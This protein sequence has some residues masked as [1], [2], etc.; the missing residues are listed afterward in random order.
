MQAHTR[1]R[2]PETERVVLDAISIEE[3]WA[4]L[5][6]FNTL[7]RLSGSQD[8]AEAVA[9]LTG[10]LDVWGVPY[11]V[12]YPICLI[13]IPVRAT[14]RVLSPNPRPIRAK[15]LSFSPSTEGAEITGELVYVPS[16]HARGV[17]ELLGAARPQ[18]EQDL[19]GKV[20]LTEGL[21]LAA[22]GLDLAKTGAIGAIFINPGD[23]IH[24]GIATTSWGSPD[25]D[26]LGRVPPVPILAI[27]R[28]DGETLK[29]E[30]ARGPVQVAFSTTVDTGWRPI[31][32]VVAEIPGTQAADEFVLFHGHLD[33][34]H[35]G[36][37]DNATGDATLL[38]IARVFWQHRDRL[39]RTL[40]IAW[41]SGHSHGRYAG[42]TWYA[43]TFA[44]DL[45]PNCIAHIN[46]DSPG[47]RW[48]TEYR[49][50]AWMA[51]A[52]EL[53][54]AT[55]RDV[56]GQEATG[57]R[58]LRAGDCS[59]NN[60]GITT[61]F[62][63]SSTMPESLIQQKGYYPVGGCGGNIQWHTEDDTIEIADRDNLLRD[64]RVYA[65]VLL[66]TLN[67]PVHPF[68]YRATVREIEEYL[69]RYQE[70][71]G[72]AFDFRPSLQ[73]AGN[74]LVTLDRFYELV[75]SLLDREVDDPEVRRVNAAQRSLARHLVPL[76]YVRAGRFR[77]DPA[78]QIPPLPEIAPA[79]EL[80]QVPAGSDR[81]HTLRTHLA[82]GQNYVV[83]S[84]RQAHRRIAEILP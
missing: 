10:R 29:A 1:W 83:W 78:Q 22:R 16:A 14:L 53:V 12:H 69:Q 39:R 31:P 68:D 5:E 59:F 36:I 73:A 33:S 17:A 45:M 11:R 8:E 35:V 81:W 37:G 82:R 38:E 84:L 42:S 61:Y 9:Y 26:S 49:D 21:G 50:V 28:P 44:Q 18:I 64:M 3:P 63:L 34:W 58:P 19:R 54:R 65:A 80:G 7:V 77:H 79:T 20:I 75:E 70:V 67:A 71:A 4:L 2:D 6:R 25:L 66:R 13:S 48:A 41:W 32:V 62:M 46:C 23:Y 60:L 51:E 30:L 15:T 76:G 55:I 47:C 72:D 52:S 74:L 43:D 27:S 40:R 24:E 56:T 57:S